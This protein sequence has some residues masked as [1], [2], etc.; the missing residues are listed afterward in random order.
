MKRPKSDVAAEFLD[1]VSYRV[2][3]PRLVDLVRRDQ[4]SRVVGALVTSAR[5]VQRRAAELSESRYDQ[6]EYLTFHYLSRHY[7]YPD[8]ASIHTNA[9]QR[10]V[11]F[12]NDIYD[13][14]LTLPVEHR[15]DARV[16]R[17]ALRRLSPQHATVPSANDGLPVA[18]SYVKSLHQLKQW[19]SI[20]LGMRKRNCEPD[21]HVRTWATSKWLFVNDRYFNSELRRLGRSEVLGSLSWIDMDFV[22]TSTE[23]FLE[24]HDTAYSEYFCDAMWGLLNIEHF[25]QQIAQRRV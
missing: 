1:S 4:K 21:H 24:N 2:K 5:E 25:L 14:Y 13:L 20:L 12:D 8:Y 7:S 10:C 19:A 3:Y 18:S 16:Q 17:L 6:W 23:E 15:F 11:S 22:R 9:E